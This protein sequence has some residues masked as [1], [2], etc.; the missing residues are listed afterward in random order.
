MERD[1]ESG[2]SYHAAR[3]YEPR[4]G[5]WI[6]ADPIGIADGPNVYSFVNGNPIGSSD[7]TGTQSEKTR[8]AHFD[9]HT[10]TYDVSVEGLG[11]SRASSEGEL[12]LGYQQ[13]EAVAKKT[14][15]DAANTEARRIR[16][17]GAVLSNTALAISLAP[18]APVVIAAGIEATLTASLIIAEYYALV[19]V[20]GSFGIGLLDPNPAGS[21]ELPGP[22][23][24]AGRATRQGLRALGGAAAAVGKKVEMS[25]EL[26]KE[27]IGDTMPHSTNPASCRRRTRISARTAV[28]ERK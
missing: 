10:I 21:F 27:L 8:E 25:P 26:E 13:L 12:K 23:D 18:V 17:E 2:L 19:A 4:L 1:E 14:R 24:N 9:E 7:R 20:V 28:D 6:S 11:K 3:L 22:F 16:E 5:R 15:V